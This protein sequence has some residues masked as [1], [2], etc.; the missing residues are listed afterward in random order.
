M[1]IWLVKPSNFFDV[2]YDFVGSLVE[3]NLK[4]ESLDFMSCYVR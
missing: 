1:I 4:V 2:E 3:G